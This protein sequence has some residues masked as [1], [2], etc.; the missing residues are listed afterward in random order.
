MAEPYSSEEVHE[1]I[2]RV[3]RAVGDLAG[4]IELQCEESGT[5]PTPDRIDHLRRM[6]EQ[7][8]T[9]LSTLARREAA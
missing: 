9:A 5:L 3:R 2:A 7:T 6:L 1:I 8:N 4:A